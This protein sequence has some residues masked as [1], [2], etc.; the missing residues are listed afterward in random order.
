MHRFNRP[1]FPPRPR[2]W[3]VLQTLE[4]T[5]PEP[6]PQEALQAA[7]IAATEP[8]PDKQPTPLP[9]TPPTSPRPG[10]KAAIVLALIKRENGAT[11]S[12]LMTAANWK[13]HS[14]TADF[15]PPLSAR[16]WA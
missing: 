16:R 11:L 3:H 13:A 9:A 4:V 12:E 10:S 7:A 6:P 15:S 5:I 2:I 1:R 14:V 8:V